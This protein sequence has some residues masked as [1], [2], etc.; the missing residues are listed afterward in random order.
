MWIYFV[1][2]FITVG[3]DGTIGGGGV[4]C[5]M[6]IVSPGVGK[7]NWK[8]GPV[9]GNALSKSYG[10]FDD[11]TYG[12]DSFLSLFFILLYFFLALSLDELEESDESELL[13]ELE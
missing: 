6:G 10:L 8:P 3:A 5:M 7:P 13:E 9:L 12:L 2:G 4:G 11:F 1:F